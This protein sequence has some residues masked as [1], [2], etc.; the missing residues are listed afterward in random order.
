VSKPLRPAFVGLVLLLSGPAF[1]QDRPLPELDSFLAQVRA[2]LRTDERLQSQYSYVERRSE[3]RLTKLGKVTTGPDKVYEVYPGS[4]PSLT[5]RR[6]IEVD[7]KPRD[8]AELREEDRDQQRKTLELLKKRERES[9]ADR[10]KRLKRRAE[11][12]AEQDQIFDD[13]ARV[14]AFTLV[15]RQT[16][17]GQPLIVIDF[18]P[19]PDAAPVTDV[20]RLMLKVKGRAWIS[21]SDYEIARA[22]LEVNDDI[23]FGWGLAG[24][25]YKGS[26]VSFERRKVN[27]EVWLPVEMRFNGTGRAFVRK[28]RIETIVRYSEYRKYSIRTDETFS[29]PPA[30]R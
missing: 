13:L 7:G 30:N 10:E 11:Q 29:L 17:A 2:H 25:L 16:A 18:T 21:E 14:F 20:G 19:K 26:S 15:G 27:D 6:L 23:S 28:F 5:Y 24:K 12:Q 4:E 3:V 9:A 22:D 1:P 8:P